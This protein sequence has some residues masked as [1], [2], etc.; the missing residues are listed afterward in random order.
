VTAMVD[1][2]IRSLPRIWTERF[3]ADVRG[4]IRWENGLLLKEG[5]I[6]VLMVFLILV[7]RALA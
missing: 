7:L 3:H 6:V 1:E 5:G 2:S 4:D